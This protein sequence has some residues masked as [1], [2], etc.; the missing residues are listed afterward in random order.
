M[1]EGLYIVEYWKWVVQ[2]T[3]AKLCLTLWKWESSVRSIYAITVHNQNSF[4]INCSGNCASMGWNPWEKTCRRHL[5]GVTKS[6]ACLLFWD[7]TYWLMSEEEKIPL[8]FMM[9]EER[10][11]AQLSA[12]QNI[13]FHGP[14]SHLTVN[15]YSR[16]SYEVHSCVCI[17]WMRSARLTL[18]A[19]FSCRTIN[20]ELSCSDGWASVHLNTYICCICPSAQDN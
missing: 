7:F 14:T 15:T 13:L 3:T 12:L 8:F 16:R 5:F 17:R 18:P 4:L 6:Y 20:Q 11:T 19:L 10:W 2:K 1:H 9:K